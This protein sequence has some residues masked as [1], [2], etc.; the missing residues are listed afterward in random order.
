MPILDGFEVSVQECPPSV[1]PWTHEH[2]QATKAIR[3][4]E[5]NRPSH[6]RIPILALTA[7]VSSESQDNCRTAGL[8]DFLP[9]PLLIADLDRALA[10]HLKIE[11]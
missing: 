5:A 4:W 7:N 3:K 2:P 6:K 1:I 11:I 10:R 9:K 8:D